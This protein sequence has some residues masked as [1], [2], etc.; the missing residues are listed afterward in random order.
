MSDVKIKEVEK[1]I[2]KVNIRK[3]RN[4]V[5]EVLD[6]KTNKKIVF[7]GKYAAKLKEL[8]LRKPTKRYITVG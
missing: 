2:E 7:H 4:E 3:K 8:H 5:F 1:P 6:T